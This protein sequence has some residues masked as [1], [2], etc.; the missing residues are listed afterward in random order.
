MQKLYLLVCNIIIVGLLAA[1]PVLADDD[2]RKRHSFKKQPPFKKQPLSVQKNPKVPV[3]VRASSFGQDPD[4][5]FIIEF[6]TVP[7]R[8]RLIM[9]YISLQASRLSSS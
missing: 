2:D 5:S 9:Q 3:Q 6:L 1:A 4:P 7:E 8:K